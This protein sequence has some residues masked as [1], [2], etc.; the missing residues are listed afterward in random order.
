MWL[1]KEKLSLA[2]TTLQPNTLNHV[3]KKKQMIGCSCMS[4]LGLKKLLIVTVDTDVVVT[5]LY[6]FWNLDLEELW[7]EFGRGKDPKWL[8]VHAYTKALGEEVC[9]AI[10]FWYAFAGCDTVSQFFGK[11]KKTA[12]NTWGRFLEATQTFI[13]LLCV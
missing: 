3:R 1:L 9:R 6:A 12:W 2:T 13:R 5:A 4:R 10:L 11:G 8:P 7:I